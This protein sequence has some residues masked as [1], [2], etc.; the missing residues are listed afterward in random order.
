MA[1]LSIIETQYEASC[2]V[3]KQSEWVA[4]PVSEGMFDNVGSS[5]LMSQWSL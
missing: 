3:L 1:A 4:S 5:E 2:L